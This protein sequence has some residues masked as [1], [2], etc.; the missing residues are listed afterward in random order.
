MCVRIWGS[1]RRRSWKLLFFKVKGESKG[2]VCFS[3]IA[4]ARKRGD[5]Y[6]NFDINVN[7]NLHPM[8]E[9]SSDQNSKSFV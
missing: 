3:E 9:E 7:K 8:I 5:I 2:H 4:G 6:K 1:K